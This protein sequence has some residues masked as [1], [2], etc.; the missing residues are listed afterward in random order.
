[1][2]LSIVIWR[3]QNPQEFQHHV[4]S[5]GQIIICLLPSFFPRTIP[6][7][8]TAFFTTILNLST[9]WA[10]N[11]LPSLSSMH[12]PQKELHFSPAS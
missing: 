2:R 10:D 4:K 8:R 12:N 11:H 9:V 7:K 5:H 6:Q 3:K 1:M